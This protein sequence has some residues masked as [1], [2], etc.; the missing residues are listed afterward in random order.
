MSRSHYELI[1]LHR[2]LVLELMIFW[3][4]VYQMSEWVGPIEAVRKLRK[5][6]LDELAARDQKLG[7]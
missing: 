2:D 3:N 6:T 1:I 4:E 5:A 7:I